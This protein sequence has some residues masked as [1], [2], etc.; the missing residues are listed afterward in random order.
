MLIFVPI[1]QFNTRF[2]FFCLISPLRA[3]ESFQNDYLKVKSDFITEQQPSSSQ[4]HTLPQAPPININITEPRLIKAGSPTENA[5]LWGLLKEQ[6]LSAM[7]LIFRFLM[8]TSGGCTWYPA[9]ALD[10]LIL[11]RFLLLFHLSFLWCLLT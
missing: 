5:S 10:Q 9:N 3:R 1:R 2:C 11:P 6:H 7:S 8:A 4:F